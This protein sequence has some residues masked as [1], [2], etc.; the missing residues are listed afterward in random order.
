[1]PKRRINYS[2]VEFRGRVLG[3]CRTLVV[4]DSRHQDISIGFV[5]SQSE[6]FLLT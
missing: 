3:L 5:P 4:S 2:E 6:A 1:M